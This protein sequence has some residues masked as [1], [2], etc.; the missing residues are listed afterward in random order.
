MVIK[1]NSVYEAQLPTQVT[2]ILDT[3]AIVVSIG[4]SDVG[5]VLECSFLPGYL[6]KLVLYMVVPPVAAFLAVLVGVIRLRCLAEYTPAALL[7]LT[8]PYVLQIFFVA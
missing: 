6:A 7:E 4:V 3:F 1:V 2:E 5:G 8:L